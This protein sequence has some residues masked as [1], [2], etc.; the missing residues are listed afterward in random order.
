[1]ADDPAGDPR[2][3]LLELPGARRA[4]ADDVVG[5]AREGGCRGDG[6]R[7]VDAALPGRVPRDDA[8][9]L[10]LPRRRAPRCAR[11][12]GPLRMAQIMMS[13]TIFLIGRTAALGCIPQRYGLSRHFFPAR[14]EVPL[15]DGKVLDVRFSTPDG[16]VHAVTRPSFDLDR[17]ET[18][19]IVG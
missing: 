19:G 2:R 10:Q 6:K 12:E 9:L 8:V 18:L 14:T 13:H 16:D 5:R 4:G 1:H 11:S 15:R 7:A 3:V 17:G